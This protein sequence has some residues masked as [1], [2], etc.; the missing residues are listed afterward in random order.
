MAD[1]EILI[2]QRISRCPVH[3]CNGRFHWY[4]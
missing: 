4:L 1:N 2:C 3:A